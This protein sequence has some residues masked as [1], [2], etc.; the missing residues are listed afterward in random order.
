MAKQK[1]IQRFRYNVVGITYEY[2]YVNSEWKQL[3]NESEEDLWEFI[4]W[5][6]ERDEFGLPL[7]IQM[8]GRMRL[9]KYR[10]GQLMKNKHLK[11]PL[12]RIG[13]SDTST[14]L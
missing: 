7:S 8:N 13:K 14:N 9:K 11:P 6:Y 3:E 12:L 2:F 1:W 4:L 5:L 10:N